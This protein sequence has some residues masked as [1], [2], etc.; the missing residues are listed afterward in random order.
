LNA[1]MCGEAKRR[2]SLKLREFAFLFILVT[3]AMLSGCAYNMSKQPRYNPMEASDFFPDRR[4]ERPVVQGTVANAERNAGA[5]IPAP[6][7]FDMLKRGRERFDIYC[8]PCHSRTGNGEGMVVQRGFPHP[9]SLFI[10]RLRQ[11]PDAHFF[12][13]I[14]EGLGRMWS[15]ADRVDAAD[16]WTVT[17]Y[18]RALQLSRS[19]ARSDVPQQELRK[20][21][22]TKP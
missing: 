9:P 4:S 2:R 22:G 7:T 3:A 11:A 10:E 15:Y 14:T 19:A 1:N 21:L 6:I 5:G 12:A 13:V 17:A 16:R 20:L 8:S 18:I